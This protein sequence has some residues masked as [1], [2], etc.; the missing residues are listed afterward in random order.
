[1]IVDIATWLL[2]V[3]T[4]PTQNATARMRIWR[5]LKGLGCA[6]LRDGAWLLPE[7][8][9]TRQGLETLVDE[10]RC[11]RRNRMVAPAGC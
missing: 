11:G 4:L 8:V 5:G 6:A 7:T 3:L 9:A 2:I 1:M 10:T